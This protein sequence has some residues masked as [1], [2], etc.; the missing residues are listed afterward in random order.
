MLGQ[1]YLRDWGIIVANPEKLSLWDRFFNRYRKTIH[2]KG[3]ESWFIVQYGV[4]QYTYARCFV[5]YLVV[6]RLTG[7]ETLKKEYLN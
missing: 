6:D 4:K 5:E 2:N 7:S 1:L 3:E